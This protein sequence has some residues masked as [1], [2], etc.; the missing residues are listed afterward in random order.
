MRRTAF[1]LVTI[2]AALAL[3][4]CPK[5][6]TDL[7]RKAKETLDGLTLAKKCAPEAYRSAMKM[8]EEAEELSKKKAY[9]EAARAAEA[10]LKLA[11]K[12][13]Q[14]AEANKKDCEKIA[15]SEDVGSKPGAAPS[16]EL[17][18]AGEKP[19]ELPGGAPPTGPIL[20]KVVVYFDFD[21]FDIR[22]DAAQ[23][24]TQFASSLKGKTDF[25]VEVEGHCD[26]RGSVEYNLALGE[27]RARA[28]RDFLVA[29]GLP[30]RSLSIIS[31]GS[32]KPA[33]DGDTEEAYAKN[34]RAVVNRR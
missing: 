27:R 7:L 20:D 33:V 21:K 31:Y 29:Q 22:P 28:V 8:Y 5:P 15:A 4:A 24:L 25:S 3:A 1:F 17:P 16:A 2:A 14:L 11:E 32:E 19:A 6:P 12:A 18:G 26:A 30:A 10:A 23:T 34:R 9:K 13:K